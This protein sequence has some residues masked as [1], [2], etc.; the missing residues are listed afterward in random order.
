[1]AARI[2]SGNFAGLAV[3]ILPVR[4][5]LPADETVAAEFLLLALQSGDGGRDQL[6]ERV[7]MLA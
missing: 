5:F 3:E 7:G 6:V 2:V 4:G 1:M